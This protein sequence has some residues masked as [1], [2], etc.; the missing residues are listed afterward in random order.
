MNKR[1]LGVIARWLEAGAPHKNGVHGFSMRELFQAGDC[2]TTCC[3]SGAAHEFWPDDEGPTPYFGQAQL[4]LTFEQAVRLFEPEG[5]STGKYDSPA[6]GARVIRKL[7]ATGEVD[8]AGTRRAK[9]A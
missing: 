8:W 6:W 1:R 7:I 4:G 5:F 3:I 2:G 9:R